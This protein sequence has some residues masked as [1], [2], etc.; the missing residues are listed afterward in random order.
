MNDVM[1]LELARRTVAPWRRAAAIANEQG[2]SNR[3]R[4]EPSRSADVE[5]LARTAKLWWQR[6]EEPLRYLAVLPTR[7]HGAATGGRTLG[8]D[9]AR[10]DR[11][12][13]EPAR[14]FDAHLS[15]EHE[16][17]RWGARFALERGQVTD[18]E[19]VR[20]FAADIGLVAVVEGLM[21]H[22]HPRQ[23]RRRAGH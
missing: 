19:K 5:W 20:T 23:T 15:T 18:Q 12:A 7:L 1:S 6:I 21:H 16:L 4:R 3:R 9:H 2:F 17:S 10:D 8:H 22:F 14:R 13:R 11:V